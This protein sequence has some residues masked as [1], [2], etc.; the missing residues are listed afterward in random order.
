MYL[1][2]DAGNSRLK[3]GA[4][5]GQHWLARAACP[6]DLPRLDLPEG[7]RARRIVVANVAGAA[8][9]GRLAPHLAQAGADIEWLR[10]EAGRCGVANDYA[11]PA[12]L[13]ADRWAAAIGAAPLLEKDGIVVCAGT[14]TTIDILRHDATGQARFAGG[15]I[16]P[17]LRMMRESL[18][19]NTA[20]LPLAQGRFAEPPRNTHDAIATGCLLAQTGAIAGMAATLPPG[21]PIVLTGGNAEM[22]LPHLTGDIRLQPWL[23]LD[24]L[25][26]IATEGCAR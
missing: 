3:Y 22:L 12:S 6:L 2:V 18:A 8:L 21:A 20:G 19:R 26:R 5:D 24:G 23:V 25:L 10:A 4:H 11:D 1:L 17:G 14:A 16:L 13:G 9:A 7:F 15:C